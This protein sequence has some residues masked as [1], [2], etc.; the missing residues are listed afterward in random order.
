MKILPIISSICLSI[1]S[2]LT[3][4]ETIPETYTLWEQYYQIEKVDPEQATRLLQ[5]ISEKSPQDPKV[6]KTWT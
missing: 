6:W 3:Q 5:Q 2:L 1:S 4:A